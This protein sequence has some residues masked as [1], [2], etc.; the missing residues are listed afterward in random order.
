MPRRE[1]NK[2]DA[3]IG[4]RLKMARRRNELTLEEVAREFEL[5]PSQISRYENGEVAI[6]ASLMFE[7]AKFFD[8]SIAF[9]MEDLQQEPMPAP[10]APRHV[11]P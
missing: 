1:A 2:F 6:S 9:L 10:D 5:S 7:F 8:V 4:R 3:A 11:K